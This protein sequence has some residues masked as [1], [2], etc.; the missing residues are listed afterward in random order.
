M[1]VHILDRLTPRAYPRTRL[2][3][4]AL[5]WSAVGF[6][7]FAKG[8][9]LFR[10]EG[11][12]IVFSTVATGVALGLL[13]SRVIL[14]RVARKIIQRIG[15]KP[16]RA[17]LG[18]L[19]SVRNWLLIAVMIVFGRLLGALPIDAGIKTGLYVMVGAGLICSSRLLWNAWKRSSAETL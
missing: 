1:P 18:G 13:K 15:A 19:F 8:C 7:L 17:C 6:F 16:A 10:G 11:L 4:A 12:G 14:D 5:V 2:L 3:T 9:Y